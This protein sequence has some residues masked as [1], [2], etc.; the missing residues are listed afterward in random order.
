MFFDV[1]LKVELDLNIEPIVLRLPVYVVLR[2]KYY[3]LVKSKLK[4]NEK[5]KCNRHRFENKI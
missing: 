4:I 2:E 3:L 1:L 5:S